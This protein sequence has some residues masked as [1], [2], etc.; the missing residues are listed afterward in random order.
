M[1]SEN[2]TFIESIERQAQASWDFASQEERELYAWLAGIVDGEGSI[3]ILRHYHKRDKRWDFYLRIKV[4]M[5]S[6]E[7]ILRLKQIAKVGSIQQEKQR[8]PHRV[9]FTWTASSREAAAVLQCCYPFLVTKKSQASLA[10]EFAESHKL[11]NHKPSPPHLIENW[12]RLKREIESGNKGLPHITG[13]G[14][15]G[16]DGSS[17]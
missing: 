2:S 6:K 9:L 4:S 10:L 7:T 17:P 15:E 16:R 14:K 1:V 3:F 11:C 8:P 13:G 5:T 12:K